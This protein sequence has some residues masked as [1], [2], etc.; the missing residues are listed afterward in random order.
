[1]NTLSEANGTFAIQLLKHLGQK[2]PVHNVFLSPVSIS[3]ALGMVLLGAKGNTASQ[4]V[5][6]LA[7]N[8]EEDIHGG[9]QSL[10][11]QVHRTGAPYSLIIAN[12]LFGE[13]SC[14]FLS[15]FRESCQNFYQAELERLPFAKDS[16]ICKRHINAWVS[17][18]TEGKVQK[19]LTDVSIDELC[20]LFLINAVYFKGRWKEQFKKSS[21]SEMTFKINQEKRR[22]VQ[23][24]FQEGM[25]PWAHV[26]E[27]GAQVLEL[28]YE[29]QE[30]SM[31]L[32]LPDK[33]VDL[34]MVEKALTFEKFQAWSS[35]EHMKSTQ[36]EVSLPR[37]K[38]QE[39]FDL[40][41]VLQALGVVDAFRPDKADLSGILPDSGLCLTR[42]VHK[43]MVEVNEEGTEAA[44]A[45]ACKTVCFYGVRGP[46]FC[47]DRPFLFFIRHNR[48]N[49]LLFCG[50]FSSP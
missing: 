21:T 19:M 6:A 44:A 4:I 26:S 20:R 38:L 29:G 8:A 3:S 39:E 18:K 43:S 9:F 47:A 42:V 14:Q 23:M 33:G 5:Q 16:L 45:L 28:P 15:S 11:A 32:L 49:I 25:F 50:K 34:S 37:F 30:L 12:R 17:R 2:D 48:T 40:V 22:P 10:L 41:S 35:S 46:V 7:L 36:V 31:I 27:V 24:M 13:E 1:M